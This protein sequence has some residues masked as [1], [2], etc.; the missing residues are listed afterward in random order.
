VTP[1]AAQDLQAY[2]GINLFGD[3][4][5][6]DEQQDQKFDMKEQKL[7]QIIRQ[8]LQEASVD[9]GFLSSFAKALEEITGR[10][11]SVNYSDDDAIT[12]DGKGNVLDIYLKGGGA[13]GGNLGG[14]VEIQVMDQRG[15]VRT[16]IEVPPEPTVAAEE[17]A[18]ELNK[19]NEMELTEDKL[20]KIVREEASEMLRERQKVAMGQDGG[21]VRLQKAD[22]MVLM[23]VKEAGARGEYRVKLLPGEAQNLIQNLNRMI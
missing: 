21:H 16:G 23:D 2:F 22:G 11:T 20:R 12:Y 1:E 6:E 14:D 4:E 13:V 3:E 19:I 8:E 17:L 7:R 18:R 10:T 9:S 5:E 15:R